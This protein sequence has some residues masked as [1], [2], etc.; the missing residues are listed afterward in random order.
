MNEIKL[1][2]IDFGGVIA[3][4]GF[5]QGI[6]ELAENYD[7]EVDALKKTAFDLVYDC[8]FTKGE[9]DSDQFWDMLKKKTGIKESNNKL[10]QFILDRFVV[11]DEMID[12]VKKLKNKNIKTA[13]L[14]DQT[15]WL[16]ELDKK[17]D[18]FKYFDHIFNS[19]HMGIT[20]KEPEMFDIALETMG[21]SPD[22]TLFIDDHNPH[23]KRAEE[24]RIKALLFKD[25]D[26]FR[27]EIKKYFNDIEI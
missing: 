5:K 23:I 15:N 16:D 26:D 10:T 3:L 2:L 20:K 4:E 27:I 25:P 7:F 24:K 6:T 9:S 11:R 19:Y 8:G 13:V 17:Y 12:F 21:E 18:F 14:S 1:V 22:N